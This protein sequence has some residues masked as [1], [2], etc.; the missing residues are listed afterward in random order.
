MK[1]V[2]T[3][4]SALLSEQMLLKHANSKANF[5]LFSFFTSDHILNKGKMGVCNS[6]KATSSVVRSISVRKQSNS[7]EFSLVV[8]SKR[9]AVPRL[10]P[11]HSNP[12][13]ARRKAKFQS[14]ENGLRSS[15][16]METYSA[17]GPLDYPGD[18]EVPAI[19]I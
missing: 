1:L 10:Q 8:N 16:G 18:Q 3:W 5:I 14:P 15:S 9:T 7:E 4:I 11:V 12:L 17:S 13:H 19:A 6:K 2:E